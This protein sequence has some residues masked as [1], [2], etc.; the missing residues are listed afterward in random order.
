MAQKSEGPDQLRSWA[1]AIAACVLNTLLSG[2]SR[3]NGLFYVALLGAYGVSRQEANLPFTLR[4]CVRNLAGPVVGAIGQKYGAQK[5]TFVGAIFATLGVVLCSLAPDVTWIS[6]FWGG[7]HGFGVALGNTLFQ[8]TLSQYFVKYR[9]TA[10]GL[11]LSGACFGSIFLPPA[12]EYMINNLGL[13][14]TFLLTG[15][16]LMH[17]LPASIMMTEPSWVKAE[18]KARRAKSINSRSKSIV[19][20]PSVTQNLKLKCDSIVNGNHL[21]PNPSCEIYTVSINEKQYNND[22]CQTTTET[23][24]IDNA[25]YT[26]SAENLDGAK[27]IIQAQDNILEETRLPTVSMGEVSIAIAAPSQSTNRL[28]I[29]QEIIKVY[30]NPMFHI[31]SLSLA[32][33]AMSFDPAITVIVDYIKDK[34]LEE[35]GAKYL[36]SIMSIGDLFGRLC[37]GWVTDNNYLSVP[38]FML[39]L[40]VVQGISFILFP[41]FNSYNVLMAIVIVYGVAAG[42]TLVMYPILIAKYLPSVASLAIGCIAFFTGIVSF[43]VPPVIGYFRDGIGSYDGMFL[44]T[45]GLSAAVGFTWLIEPILVK[46]SKP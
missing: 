30:T 45:G 23:E 16:L 1:I 39:L 33:F 19:V 44:I 24:G 37:F 17:A 42:I 8:V 28:T 20:I 26:E 18:M 36:I 14:G 10:T 46:Y 15:G 4:N 32:A 41:F 6:I 5:V 3:A 2:I 12:L 11:A 38:K 35:D 40:H 27:K 7:I 31:I 25:A 43:A 13:S 21:K 29:Y 34:G 9:A 22:N